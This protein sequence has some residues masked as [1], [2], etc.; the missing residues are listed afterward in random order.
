MVTSTE[1]AIETRMDVP[2]SR[3]SRLWF[4][5]SVALAGF[6]IVAEEGLADRYRIDVSD[7]P[8][9]YLED[10]TSYGL[11]FHP[12]RGLLPP[13]ADLGITLSGGPGT[14]RTSLALPASDPFSVQVSS[15]GPYAMDRPQRD[16]DALVDPAPPA[17]S[18]QFVQWMRTNYFTTDPAKVLAVWKWYL[19]QDPARSFREKCE[20]AVLACS[21]AM[22]QPVAGGSLDLINPLATS[23]TITALTS[24]SPRS[25]P[26][27]PRLG[28]SYSRGTRLG[29]TPPMEE[30]WYHITSPS[31]WI[32]ALFF[33]PQ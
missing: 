22:G 8:A 16:L 31:G 20:N 23:G 28:T 13:P 18:A 27:G 10:S 11:G 32:I 25:Y 3:S 30:G 29:L 5:L 12:D 19:E 6:V 9:V 14:G 15:P 1:C 2:R 33:R 4:T 26:W 7:L 21:L 17:P 24:Q